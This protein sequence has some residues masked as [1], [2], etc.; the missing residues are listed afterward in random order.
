ML[1]I[2][3]VFCEIDGVKILKEVILYES[4]AKASS[5]KNMEFSTTYLLRNREPLKV[6]NDSKLILNVTKGPSQ[7]HLQSKWDHSKP[8]GVPYSS[9]K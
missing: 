1:H 8:S 3:T 5:M 4:S 6:M 7:T 9:N 2:Y